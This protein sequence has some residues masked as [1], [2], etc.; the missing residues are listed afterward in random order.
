MNLGLVAAFGAGLASFLSPCVLPLVP[1][2]LLYLA[3]GST[4]RARVLGRAAAFVL[5]FSLVFVG[6]GLTSTAI[7]QFLRLNHV[8]LGKAAGIFLVLMGVAMLG[9]APGFLQR[10]KRLRLGSGGALLVGMVFA[11]GWTPCVGPVLAAV[12][13]LAAQATDLW[14]GGFLLLV[15]AIGLAVPFLLCA[16]FLEKIL[17]WV[18]RVG[19]LTPAIKGLT[20]ALMVGLGI[21]MYLGEFARL[22]AYLTIWGG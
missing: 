9:L 12:L 11:A 8:V 5:G 14:A 22:S 3:G 17:P 1:T 21:M 10:E 13:A 4:D 2:Y 16:Y 18:R 19:P 6:M 7:G 15:Y 20:G